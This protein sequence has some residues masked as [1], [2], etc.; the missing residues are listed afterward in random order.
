[1][2]PRCIVKVLL[3]A[4][5]DPVV[6]TEAADFLRRWDLQHRCKVDL[7]RQRSYPFLPA[8]PR[9]RLLGDLNHAEALQD[10]DIAGHCAPVTLQFLRQDADRCRRLANLPEQKHSLLS[11]NMQE[12]LNVFKGD[13]STRRNGITLIRRLRKSTP[14]FKEHVHSFHANFSSDFARA[15]ALTDSWLRS[16]RSPFPPP[17]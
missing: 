12:R 8:V 3:D 7:A 4:E 10:V 16:T 5:A 2:I 1:M 9:K 11:Q 13:Y 6:T 14:P 15:S 17:S